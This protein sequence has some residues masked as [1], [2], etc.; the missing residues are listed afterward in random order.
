[1]LK[2]FFV[3]FALLISAF[4]VAQTGTTSPYSFFGLGEE[5]FKGTVEN[6]GM[7]GIGVYSDSIHMTLQNPAH[8]AELRLVNYTMGG[9]YRYDMLKTS[10]DSD[11]ASTV[12][13]DYLAL[14][15]PIGDKFGASFGLLPLTT[16]GYQIES[17]L[18]P[19][20]T[21]FEG[22]GGI[23]R[24][25]VAAAYKVFKGLNIGAELNYNFGN[26]ENTTVVSQ[27][28]VQYGTREFN[29]S[30][31]L[32]LSF[33]FGIAYKTMITE[34]L[35]LS[36]SLTFAPASPFTAE[37]QRRLSTVVVTNF[38]ETVE[39]DARDVEVADVDFDFP[40]QLDIGVGIGRPKHWFIGAEFSNFTSSDFVNRSFDLSN[41]TFKDAKRYQVGGFIIPNYN[42]FGR[43]FR[44]VVYRG[45][46]RFEETGINVRGEDIDE[47]GISFGLGLPVGR[48]FSNVNI[49]FE[50]GMRGTKDFGL[51]QENFFNTFISL[52]LNDRWFEKRFYD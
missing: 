18:D 47:F 37:N 22:T 46:F 43:Y 23:N 36:T 44:R 30:D 34:V 17:Q 20:I 8:L 9:S 31:I 51:I 15:V 11:Q 35:E 28:N 14:G 49:T 52:S 29:K 24:V 19:T 1:M 16:V 21:Q 12:S 5:K 27:E 38:G 7:G 26:I 10:I 45:G 3:A 4:A 48:L 39:I 33:N 25:F 42:A 13:L 32:G 50:Y 40:S 41:V 2:R 6:R